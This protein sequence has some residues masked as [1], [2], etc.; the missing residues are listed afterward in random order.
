M[1]SL[2][3]E[4]RLSWVLACLAMALW[5]YGHTF[6]LQFGPDNSFPSHFFSMSDEQED[7]I[8]EE[9]AD[10]PQPHVIETGDSVKVKQVLDD[11][12]M[13]ILNKE[14]GFATNYFWENIKLLLMFLSCVFAM[15]AQFYPIPFPDSRP[16]LGVCCAMYF[17]LSSVLQFM[18]TYI[19]KDI[20]MVS[21]PDADTG[22]VMCVRTNFPRFYEYF[23]LIIQYQEPNIPGKDHP[24]SATI[25]KMYVGRYFTVKGEFDEAAYHRDVLIH[26][27]RFRTKK[28][29][30][31]PYDHKSD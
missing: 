26:M 13:E 4:T 15:A 24:P 22:K 23:S 11:A 25:A 17:I 10:V 7:V 9:C 2:A 19:D 3:G 8:Y 21:K 1:L 20:I 16:L 29:Q 14:G 28:Y 30:E 5:I 27:E 6:T 18:I 12:T 31:F